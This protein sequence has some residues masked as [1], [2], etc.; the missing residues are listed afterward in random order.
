EENYVPV[1]EEH[2]LL[3]TTV[4]KAKGREFDNV[5]YLPTSRTAKESFVDMAVYS[6]IK[7]AKGIDIHEELDE[8][9]IRVDFVAFTRAKD[10]LYV[11]ANQKNDSRY[12]VD[13]FETEILSTDDEIAPDDN[14]FNEAYAMFVNGR[15]DDAR[16]K[17]TPNDPWM[18]N[19]IKNYF[20][21]DK[22]L[23]YSLLERAEDPYELL[24]ERI[25]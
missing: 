15:E 5:I 14:R 8:E 6:I 21:S 9:Q 20:S 12:T 11:V 10:R 17:I 16:K 24:K 25:L 4:H 3:L 13:G 22:N 19:L 7:A 1:E 2:N 23:S 18:F